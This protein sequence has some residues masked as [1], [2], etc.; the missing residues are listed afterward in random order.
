MAMHS[1]R[2]I[3]N[4]ALIGFMGAANRPWAARRRPVAFR[5]FD[6]TKSSSRAPAG[7]SRK[8]LRP[9]ANRPFANW[10]RNSSKN[11]PRGPRLSSLR[12]RSADEPKNLACLKPTR[13]SSVCGRRRKKSG[14][15]EEPD[16]PAFAARCR[17]AEKNPRTA[18][19]AEPFYRQRRAVEHRAAL[20]P[21]SGAAGGASI[22]TRSL[23][24]AMKEKIRQR[25]LEWDLTIA[26]SR[27]PMCPQVRDNFKIGW[28]KATRRDGLAR[29]QRVE[30][31]APRK[32][33]PVQKA[34]SCWRPAMRQVTVS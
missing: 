31:T 25:A 13:W 22:S 20:H 9:T 3:V 1:D 32:S 28:R 33:C 23:R 17:S 7:P 10:N 5:S 4:I 30:R 19:R 16:A 11:S 34:S 2:R 8:F 21:R 26:G 27:R 12:W 6:T 24:S 29:T 14:N 15:G 18:R